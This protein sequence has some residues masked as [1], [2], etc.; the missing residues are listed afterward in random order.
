MSTTNSNL[1]SI[2]VN[3]IELASVNAEG[4]EGNRGSFRPSISADGRYVAF[5]SEASDLSSEESGDF[6][7][8]FVPALSD[9][10]VY[11]RETNT[12]E[13][14]SVDVPSASS[15]SAAENSYIEATISADGRYVLFGNGFPSFSGA[16]SSPELFIYDRQT[17]SFESIPRTSESFASFSD[18]TLSGD[19]E[20]VVFASSGDFAVEGLEFGTNIFV[21][22]RS[23]GE[24]ELITEGIDGDGIEGAAYRPDISTNGRYITYAS[25]ALNLVEDAL[26][27]SVLPSNIFFYDRETNITEQISI[28]LD[29]GIADGFSTDP[30]V[31]DDGRFIVFSSDA[32]NLVAGDDNDVVD[33]FLYDR[34]NNQTRILTNL[35][36]NG[37]SYNPVISSDGRYVTFQSSATNLETGSSGSG[38][39]PGNGGVEAYSYDLTTGETV[40]VSQPV[41][42]EDPNARTTSFNPVPSADGRFIA[43]QS[44][45]SEFVAQSDDSFGSQSSSDVF[46]YD[47]DTQ[48]PFSQIPTITNVTTVEPD[49]FYN[50]GD[51]LTLLVE[52]S[53]PVVVEGSPSLFIDTG[54]ND[55]RG[56]AAYI[57]GSGSTTL[58]FGYT[59]R[60]GDNAVDLGSLPFA[61]SNISLDSDS[62]ITNPVGGAD[63]ELALPFAGSDNSLAANR[64]I[65]LD[66][67][68]PF[69]NSV[70]LPSDPSSA[71][72]GDL[73]IFE[74]RFSEP[75]EVEGLPEIEIR[76][77]EETLRGLLFGNPF[78]DDRV[79]EFEYEV[80][81]GDDFSQPLSV[82]SLLLN[83]GSILDRAGNPATLDVP[84][85]N[86]VVE[87]I[88]VDSDGTQNAGFSFNPTISGDG[89]FVAFTSTDSDLIDSDGIRGSGTF[90]FD[91]ETQALDRIGLIREGEL[92]TES[93]DLA[94][95]ANGEFLAFSSL[96]S[97]WIGEEDTNGQRD[98]FVFDVPSG[99][100]ERVSISGLGEESNGAA[101]NPDIS[102]D[103]RFVVF[104]S[105]ATNLVPSD[106]TRAQDIFI[107]DRDLDQIDLISFLGS[108]GFSANPQIS[109]DGRY[110]VFESDENFAFDENNE[111]IVNRTRN[112]YLY[113]VEQNALQLVT[114]PPFN[115]TGDETGDAFS[116][117]AV[118]SAEG[119]YVVYSSQAD[120]LTDDPENDN[121]VNIFVYDI[122]TNATERI[123]INGN[124]SGVSADGRYISFT[125]IDSTLVD[126]D[127]NNAGDVFIYDR[128]TETV[129]LASVSLD[130]DSGDRTSLSSTLS[131]NG[132]FVAFSSQATDLVRSDTNGRQDIFVYSRGQQTPPP[133]STPSG[134]IIDLTGFVETSVAATIDVTR[135]AG[136]ENTVGFYRAV[137]ELGAVVDPLTGNVLAP[138]DVG[139]RESAIANRL[140]FSLTGE[141][142]QTITYNVDL[143]SGTFLSTF[144]VAN[145][146]IDALVDADTTNDPQIFFGYAS[147]NADGVQHVAALGNNSFGY[148]DIFGGGD[149]DFNDIVV[150]VTI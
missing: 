22:N 20:S 27:R 142:N 104:E 31:S 149:M 127:N 21:Y 8:P 48:V 56:E 114:S 41:R 110:V 124:V 111:P 137:D 109:S 84:G 33:I 68:A 49:G 6:S 14:I 99:S 32:D 3:E 34:E 69:L 75:V 144:I 26:T 100:V 120:N 150:E 66:T 59:V 54:N 24:F 7:N 70:G 58:Q 12:V 67:T 87:R 86:P 28:A 13:Q 122:R 43:F 18:Y 146:T 106:T 73:I 44:N 45:S 119:R 30:N 96:E 129:E 102:G 115:P 145:G 93:S 125:S 50:E 92:V 148:E 72:P 2:L 140:D 64:D 57:S 82:E 139:Y 135:E 60:A 1:N 71:N 11:D 51:R 35:E 29:G 63:A 65:V 79:L 97:G 105:S 130:G 25:N 131:D 143:P 36:S 76:L 128:E 5:S 126:N 78:G 4:F 90:I 55:A 38:D 147:A 81:P 107:Y 113:E 62:S 138:G 134:P 94:L 19:G 15:L 80:Q 101:F 16:S 61:F 112:I 42:S 132:Q 40:R 85:N 10:F 116:S 136:F 133:P 9:I 89:R 52:F 118:I 83:G 98:I 74:L 77:G 17:D 121:F 47:R 95:S 141:N 103:G 37:N 39:L 123:D 23:S 53:T 108:N 117:N 91:R 88:S 46:I